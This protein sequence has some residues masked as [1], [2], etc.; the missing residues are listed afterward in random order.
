MSAPV[1][2]TPSPSHLGQ[3]HGPG[4]DLGA[5]HE[6][7]VEMSAE[8][9]ADILRPYR[10]NAKYLQ[11]AQI[12]QVR[13][14]DRPAKG[15]PMLTAAGSFSIPESCYIDDTGHFNAVE[16]NICYNQLAYAMF[17]K[18]F[19]TGIV[20]KLRFLTPGEYR[21]HQLQSCFI[22]SLESR[23]L[24]QMQGGAFRGELVLNKLSWVSGMLFCFTE[25]T[26][27]DCE[28]VKAQGSVVLA[29]NPPGG[30]AKH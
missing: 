10:A 23:F 14:S 3:P 4:A 11:S 12:T 28:G 5:A 25:I 17:G 8:F 2:I 29:F 19:E 15:V 27:S 1:A 16:F 22:V 26:F 7:P 20:P 13:G 21:Q 18:C 6:M 30:S 24:K 9:V